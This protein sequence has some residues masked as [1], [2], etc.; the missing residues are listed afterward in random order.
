MSLIRSR[1]PRL[2]AAAIAVITFAPG[3]AAQDLRAAVEAAWQ[4]QPIAQ[5]RA[6]RA[7]E[8]D[9]RRAAAAAMLPGPPV[10]G[11]EH[12]TDL[13][14]R[15]EGLRKFT[16]EIAVPLWLPGQQERAQAVVGADRAAYD[17]AFTL[18][19]LALAGEVRDAYW[20]ARAAETDA[21]LARSALEGLLALEA[22]VARRV[23]AGELARVDGNRASAEAQFQRIAVA[24][25]LARSLRAAETFRALTGFAQLPA[26]DEAR[27]TTARPGPDTHPGT[28]AAGQTVE[29]ARARLRQVSGDTRDAPELGLGA[30]QSRVDGTRPWEQTLLVRM[31]IPFGNEQRNRPR[32]SAAN[33]DLI[34]A[35][36]AQGR[37]AARLTAEM[38]SAERELATALAALPLAESRAALARDTQALIA[39]GFA[40]GEFDLPT[41]L[42]AEREFKE[43]EQGN[44]RALIEAGRANSRLKQAYGVMP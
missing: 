33:A 22:D 6:A 25:A 38:A 21:S 10:L 3:L 26:N 9:A 43:A 7:D 2:A 1:M 20:Q 8:F 29:A 36:S 18:A 15:N 27:D 37:I 19:R 42:R 41:R 4:R 39:R 11:V 23:K 5:A 16:G 17:A 14:S 30:S 32:I 34:E 12:E 35:Q 24:E 40:A 28:T 31:R 44:A 13:V